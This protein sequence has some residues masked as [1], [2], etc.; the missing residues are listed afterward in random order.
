MYTCSSSTEIFLKLFLENIFMWTLNWTFSHVWVYI[1]KLTLHLWTGLILPP[2]LCQHYQ[3]KKLKFGEVIFDKIS[4]NFFL[5]KK[6]KKTRVFI[7]EYRSYC[8]DWDSILLVFKSFIIPQLSLFGTDEVTVL[9]NII[10]DI[11]RYVHLASP[12]CAW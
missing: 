4:C 7:V 2:N 3:K 11:L 6:P 12:C 1:L 5:W 9:S 8:R 10:T